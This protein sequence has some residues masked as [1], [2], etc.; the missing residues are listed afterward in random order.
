MD[1][2]A[3]IAVGGNALIRD[4]QRG[5]I[6]EQFENARATVRPI[7]ALVAG[8]W[9]IVLTHGNGPQVGFILLR[10]EL[11]GDS[12]PVPR[13]TLD[14]SVADSQGG[15][16]YILDS[17]LTSEL[18]RLGLRDRVAC[19]LTH[20]VVARDD[21]AF[22]KPSKPIGPWYAPD[23]A[24]EMRR[25]EGWAMVEDAGRGYR[26]VVP[27][28]KPLRIV[29]TAQIRTLLEAGF[30][31]VA[32]GG[33]GIPVLEGEPGVY[34]GIEAVIDKDLASGLLA[35]AL[36]IPLLIV[37]TGVD[38]VALHFRRPDQ[39]FLDRL[40]LSEAR[41][42]LNAGEFPPGSMG[43][44]IQAA[45]T[46]LEFGGREVLITSPYR[47]DEAVAGATGT[48]IVPDDHL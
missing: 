36:G 28:P 8:G 47:L 17:S 18:G 26:R 29:E 11:V 25:R 14:I 46:F 42:W 19:V 48:R 9:K 45:I 41:R 5:S 10:S 6:A 13:L 21:P 37:S 35:A 38:K 2:R 33:G 44:K 12:A 16:G 4:G 27:S 34:H 32:V 7:A 3:V 20:T 15:I 43:P 39:R 23:Q 31:V 40:T 30:V 22:Q 24:A 1:R